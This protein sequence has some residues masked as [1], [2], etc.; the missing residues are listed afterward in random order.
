M[1]T[2]RQQKVPDDARM[3]EEM[4]VNLFCDFFDFVIFKFR[5]E[6]EEDDDTTQTIP[7]YS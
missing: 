2:V 7:L 3:S 4:Y 5:G 1:V 6:F